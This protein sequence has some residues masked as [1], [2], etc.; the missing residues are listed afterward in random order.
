MAEQ[1]VAKF[2]KFANKMAQDL[3]SDDSNI[4]SE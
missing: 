3:R 4:F 2:S 1:L